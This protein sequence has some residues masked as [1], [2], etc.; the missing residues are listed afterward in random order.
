MSRRLGPAR[1]RRSISVYRSTVNLP[2]A[3][4]PSRSWLPTTVQGRTASSVGSAGGPNPGNR[5]S[6]REIARGL[7][8]GNQVVPIQEIDWSLSE[9]TP[10]AVPDGLSRTNDG[11][12]LSRC[13]IDHPARARLQGWP[14]EHIELQLAHQERDDTSAA[15]NHALYLEPRATMM[16]A[17]ADH[18]EA[19]RRRKPEQDQRLAA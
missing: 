3:M 12:R 10:H 8:R 4:R 6:R 17:W 9:E 1:S 2:R 13:R 18:L 11:V 7:I 15:Y 14:H 19:L 16:Q 5:W